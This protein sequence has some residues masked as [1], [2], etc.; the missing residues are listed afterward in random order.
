MT[1]QAWRS[2]PWEPGSLNELA[3]K[4]EA[5]LPAITFDRR[6]TSGLAGDPFLEWH[7]EQDMLVLATL[8]ETGDLITPDLLD[9]EVATVLERLATDSMD[10]SRIAEPAA[11]LLRRYRSSS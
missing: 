2:V 4:L 9:D 7:Y 1:Q 10:R 8:Y 11:R 6:K 3:E 5:A